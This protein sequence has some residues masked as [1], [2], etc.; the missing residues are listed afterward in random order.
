MCGIAGIVSF[1]DNVK[2]DDI[3]KM[4]NALIHRG[5]NGEGQ[6]INSEMKV[7]L[8]HRRLAIIDLTPNASQPMS[9]SEGRLNITFNG[10]IY[11][12]IELRE[13]LKLAGYTFKSN[14][15]SEIILFLYKEG[16]LKWEVDKFGNDYR[17]I[18]AEIEI[19][20][21]NFKISFPDYI[22]EMLLLE[23]T[24]IKQFSNRSLSLQIQYDK[25]LLEYRL[26][27]VRGTTTYKPWIH[28]AYQQPGINLASG[29]TGS[30]ARLQA[31]TFRND[32]TYS[33]NLVNL[34]PDSALQY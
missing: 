10:E 8:G 23:V 20:K 11:N 6:W 17:L 18:I 34:L 5:P 25:L 12:Y 26:G 24:G 21:K 28:I 2:A 4:T 16:E 13:L 31:L 33:R 32:T 1:K 9:Y 22:T 14:S 19:P 30:Q 29:R 7:G 15:D 27:N 3:K